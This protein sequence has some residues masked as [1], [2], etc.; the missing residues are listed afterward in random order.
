MLSLA[1][2]LL[3]INARLEMAIKSVPNADAD[4]ISWMSGGMVVVTGLA[5][6]FI[7]D[8]CKIHCASQF[9]EMRTKFLADKL[10]DWRNNQGLPTLKGSGKVAMI[11]A[12]KAGLRDEI[13]IESSR[14][15]I[16]PEEDI[17]TELEE[18]I[19]E[20]E[21]KKRKLDNGDLKPKKT[22]KYAESQSKQSLQYSTPIALNALDSDKF[23]ATLFPEQEK[24]RMLN[25][26]KIETARQ[27]LDAD[28]GQNS[29]LLKAVIDM[30]SKNSDDKVQPSSCI[31]LLY[32]WNAR[33]KNKLD[34]LE[35]GT[36][37]F[38]NSDNLLPDDSLKNH[39][40]KTPLPRKTASDDPFDALS[41]TSKDFLASMNISTAEQFLLARTKDIAIAFVN[42][43]DEMKLAPLKGLGAVASVSGWKKLVRNKAF[44]V[45]D[46]TLAQLNQASNMKVVGDTALKSTE[47]KKEKKSDLGAVDGLPR[48]D[49]SMRT[50]SGGM[51]RNQFSAFSVQKNIVFHFELDARQGPKVDRVYLTYLGNDSASS[52]A[53]CA[54]IEP[55]NDASKI[56]EGSISTLVDLGKVS[57]PMH[58]RRPYSSVTY[59]SIELGN[60]GVQPRVEDQGMYIWNRLPLNISSFASHSF[61]DQKLLW[62]L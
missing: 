23:F 52:V 49:R 15:K 54:S 56:K 29:M 14:G 36:V 2:H 6:D 16:V 43:R 38:E 61:L 27:Y 34:E 60:R 1:K 46:E 7:I 25:S 42:W 13:E 40:P 5:K 4:K 28:K 33:V 18:E 37:H 26:I 30:K 58:G 47:K 45:G 10:S 21:Q 51:S 12:W 8:H 50:T 32:E 44:A 19:D 41:T 20:P 17:L 31:R 35:S 22:S 53:E 39:N 57:A 3:G 48:Q 59:G 11:S 24:R 62:L 55:S 9:V